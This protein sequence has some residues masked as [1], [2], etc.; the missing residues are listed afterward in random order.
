[1]IN[2]VIY[3]SLNKE[4]RVQLIKAWT[5]CLSAV[6]CIQMSSEDADSQRKASTEP[7]SGSNKLCVFDKQR[8]QKISHS[9]I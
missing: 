3:F 8:S 5:D 4:M 6:C 2:P 7:R 1:M 9:L